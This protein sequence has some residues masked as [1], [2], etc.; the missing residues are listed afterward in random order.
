MQVLNWPWEERAEGV[1]DAGTLKLLVTAAGGLSK[2]IDVRDADSTPEIISMPFSVV[3]RKTGR[4]RYFR[5]IFQRH[6]YRLAFCSF[7][8]DQLL[9]N[10][11]SNVPCH[12]LPSF[13]KSVGF[14]RPLLSHPTTTTT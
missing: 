9:T 5:L 2:S 1:I 12:L 3:P 13:S 10:C 8:A 7:L 6:S 4:F 11:N 14:S